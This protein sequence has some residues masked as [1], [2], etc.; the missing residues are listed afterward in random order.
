MLSVLDEIASFSLAESW[1]NVGLMLGDPNQEI[2]GILIALDPTEDLLDEAITS[3]I[4]TIIT[5]HPLIFNPITTIRTD[6]PFGRILKKALKN[7]IAVVGCHTNLDIVSGG[8]NDILATK[9]GLTDLQPLY[10]S[11]NTTHEAQ[12]DTSPFGMGRI[13]H[14]SPP[15]DGKSLMS[16]LLSSL[17]IKAVQIVG[18]LPEEISTAAVCGGSGSD[19]AETAFNLGAQVYITS[20]IKH[21]VARWAEANDFCMLDAGH[22][23]TENVI[24]PAFAE[25]L[26]KAFTAKNFA[27]KIIQ[28]TKQVN[29]F[30]YCAKINDSIVIQ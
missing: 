12:T 24:V 7:N 30:R 3:G 25:A 18:D 6:Q 26:Q 9:L 28:T 23:S 17:D 4:N 22:F 11:K 19:L 5:H 2:S 1:D 16:Q 14:F 10:P 13:G 15:L 27:T 20:E 8:V 29:P 21:N